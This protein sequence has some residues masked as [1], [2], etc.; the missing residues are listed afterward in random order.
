MTMRL[1]LAPDKFKGTFSAAQV[2]ALLKR[3]ILEARADWAV[4]ALPLAD[5]GEGTLDV[6]MGA[7]GGTLASVRVRGPMGEIVS[8]EY[9]VASD[10]LA[11]FESARFCGLQ[12]VPP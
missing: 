2:C 8:A 11:V 1:L 3:G 4:D 12:L 7:M 6:V 10:G 5:G 9:G